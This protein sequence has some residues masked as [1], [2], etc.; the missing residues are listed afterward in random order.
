MTF[1]VD[2]SVAMSWCFEDEATSYT[3][4]V[5]ERLR[6]SDAAAPAIWPLEVANIL[7]LGERRGRIPRPKTESFVR[8]L[9]ELRVAVEDGPPAA[10]LGSV[11]QIGREY[12][13]TSYDASYLELAM[14]RGLPLATL[15]GRLADAAQRASVKLVE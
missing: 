10:V 7:L 9:Q 12:G 11:L 1:V 6:G 14:R 13:L 3:E 5:L 8:V 4:S 15:D 2:A